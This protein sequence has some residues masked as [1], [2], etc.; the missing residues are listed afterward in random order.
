M[1]FI[2]IEGIEGCGKSTQASRLARAWAGPVVLT[3]EPGGTEL[4]RGIRRLLLGSEP[5]PIAPQAEVMLFM[6]DRAQHVAEV[7]RPALAAGTAVISDRYLDSSLAYQGYGRGL[8]L[9]LLR[10]AATLATGGLEPDVT[11][12]VDVPV[13]L[14]LNRIRGRGA[15]D[16]MEREAVDFHERVRA[17]FLDLASGAPRRFLVVDGT[18]DPESVF[19]RVRAGLLPRLGGEGGG[20]R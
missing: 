15:H 4:G 9:A 20:L 11:V 1:A 8:P 3:R 2:T 16:R 10:S 19:A 13:D 12:L 18:G 5:G 17:G 6:A 14:G 7:I